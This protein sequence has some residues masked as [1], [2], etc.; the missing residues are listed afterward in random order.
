MN[1]LAKYRI[2]SMKSFRTDDG[3]AYS[4]K[5]ICDGKQVATFVDHGDGGGT[6]VDFAVR[7][8]ELQFIDDIAGAGFDGV[9][10][11]AM[12]IARLADATE[13]LKRVKKDFRKFICFV[14]PDHKP[15]EYG[16]VKITS[17][18][19]VFLD[20]ACEYISTKY[21]EAVIINNESEDVLWAR[22]LSWYDGVTEVA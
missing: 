2:E 16:T 18:D 22:V 20:R 12:A 1:S 15:S 3:M 6:N 19:Q 14:R 8:E 21:P 4:G 13:T 5:L 11:V 9:E 10:P 17:R 7:A